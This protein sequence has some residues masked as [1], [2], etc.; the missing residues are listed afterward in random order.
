MIVR[1]LIAALAMTGMAPAMAQE[2]ASTAQAQT[3]AKPAKVK[4]SCRN[5]RATES[6]VGNSRTCLTADQ[7]A[8]YDAA[9]NRSTEVQLRSGG[10]SVARR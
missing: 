7:W 1:T 3:T 10:G 6:R 5:V 8:E 9:M 2:A 4:K